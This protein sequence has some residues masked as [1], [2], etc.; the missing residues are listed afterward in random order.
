MT[1]SVRYTLGKGAEQQQSNR[2]QIMRDDT[3]LVTG[4]RQGRE[5]RL[6][7][8]QRQRRT[9]PHLASPFEALRNRSET[10]EVGLQAKRP[11]AFETI[12]KH[13]NNRTQS[14]RRDSSTLILPPWCGVSRQRDK[15]TRRVS[16]P[17]GHHPEK[18]PPG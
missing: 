15:T 2:V 5:T 10:S 18:P 3:A 1:S 13:Y 8:Q 4:G 12:P 6:L 16:T 17:F 7:S 14:R 9:R 11:S